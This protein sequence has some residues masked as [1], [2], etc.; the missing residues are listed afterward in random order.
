[1]AT[2]FGLDKIAKAFRMIK[3]YGGIRATLYQLYRTN[4]LKDGILVG[5]DALGNKYYENKQLT[6]GRNRWVI[7][8]PRVGTDY[9]GSMV[10]AEWFGWLHHMADKPPTE[11][12]PTSY[13]WQSGHEENKT[14]TEDAYMPYS[15]TKPKIQAWIPPKSH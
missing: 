8:H 6:L 10:P 1:M 14:G 12:P 11:V 13:A 5:E 2:Y 7:Y 4:D 15:T 3:N 9:E